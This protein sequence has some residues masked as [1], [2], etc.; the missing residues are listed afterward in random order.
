M[1]LWIRDLLAQL[2]LQTFPKTSGSK[3]L[4]LYVPLNTPVTYEDTKPFSH[5][6]A[7]LLEKQHPELVLSSMSKAARERKVFVDWSQNDRI[8]TT[9]GVYSLRAKDFPTVSTPVAW[10]EV[11]E[12]LERGDP[13]HLS[14]LSD[15]V[16]ARY[17]ELGDIFLPVQELKQKLPEL[18][19]VEPKKAK[20][21]KPR[22]WSKPKS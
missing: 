6:I 18:P 5:A 14:F 17:E 10:T 22:P 16:L 20:A 2:K 13:D 1:G 7:D 3:G 11:E 8:K 9:V 15:E 21:H 12:C 19:G 4:Q